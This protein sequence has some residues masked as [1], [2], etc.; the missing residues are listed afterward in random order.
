[1]RGRLR[2]GISSGM[3]LSRAARCAVFLAAASAASCAERALPRR[4]L[5][6]RT[7]SGRDVTLV[8]EIAQTPET[9][10]RGFMHRRSIPDGT[11]MLFVFERDQVMRFWMK[12]TPT[13]LSIA[14]IDSRGIIQDIFDMTP[15]S[16]RTIESSKSMRYA[17]ETPQ[18][19]FARAGIAVGDTLLPW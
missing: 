7:V 15:F 14:Y 1:L 11:G 5:T 17:L 12:D 19:W 4:E 18:G 10:A 3:R 16:L 2:C 6:I 13:A 9:R 8:A